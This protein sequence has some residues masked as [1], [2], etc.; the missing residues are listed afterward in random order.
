LDHQ[1]PRLRCSVG[2]TAYNEEANIGRLL[3]ALLAQHLRAVEISE[4]IV[5]ASGCTDN[6]IPIV[7][8]YVADCTICCSKQAKS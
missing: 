5:V 8:S 6:T 2:V 1:E 7:E 3:D 4:I